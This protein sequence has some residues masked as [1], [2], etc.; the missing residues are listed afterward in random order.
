MET[1]NNDQI[2]SNLLQG[3]QAPAETLIAQDSQV[4]ITT[5][6]VVSIRYRIYFLIFLVAVLLFGN[7]VL[8]PAWDTFQT[9][10]GES[11]TVALQVAGFATKK[12]QMDADKALIA[13]MES[14]QNII[15][16]CL[17]DRTS[18]KEI[19][20]SIRNN[21]GFAR[22][23]I[24]LNNLTDP[25]MVINERVLL[26]NINEYLLKDGNGTRNGSIAKIAIG[27]PKQYAGN[28]R[29][30]PLQLSISFENKDSLLSFLSNVET[31][32][33]PDPAYR[34]LYKIDKVSYDIANYT[35]KQSVSI[36]LNAYYYTN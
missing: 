34:V 20:A 15:V 36:D 13:K 32:I 6:R 31:R 5:S 33:L 35:E 25:K 30:A 28:L 29:Y 16:S 12:L 21:F 4:M 24:Q 7:Y 1:P 26:A 19:D 22:S 23:Y 27:E 3:Q 14:Q 18:C 17:N 10:R 2:I 11:Q 9:T 8:L